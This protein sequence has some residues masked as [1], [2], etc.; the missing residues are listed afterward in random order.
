MVQL[1]SLHYHKKDCSTTKDC[2]SQ[3]KQ[4]TIII[5]ASSFNETDVLTYLPAVNSCLPVWLALLQ[6]S[7]HSLTHLLWLIS[8]L[9]PTLLFKS[10]FKSFSSIPYNTCLQSLTLLLLS[11]LPVTLPHWSAFSNL[12]L[13]FFSTYCFSCSVTYWFLFQFIDMLL[14][15]LLSPTGTGPRVGTCK[16]RKK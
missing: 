5:A 15:R 6:R 12:S 11:S 7:V 4:E 9:F 13:Q 8:P 2:L 1:K 16:E 14:L 10:L 3:S